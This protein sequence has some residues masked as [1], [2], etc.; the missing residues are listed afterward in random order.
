MTKNNNSQVKF[1]QESEKFGA[2]NI[3]VTVEDGY[4]IKA[5]IQ[6][7]SEELD[8]T[9]DYNVKIWEVK[10]TKVL[11]V[12]QGTHINADNDVLNEIEDIQE[13]MKT[14]SNV[15]EFTSP[16]KKRWTEHHDGKHYDYYATVEIEHRGETYELTTRTDHYGHSVT[17]Q[18][19]TSDIPSEVVDKAKEYGEDERAGF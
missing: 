10:E 7:A 17:I 14:D 12:E 16:V 5:N 13:G 2:F 1:E 15:I 9:Y 6:G 3:I 4:N 18:D 8:G 19:D 11:T